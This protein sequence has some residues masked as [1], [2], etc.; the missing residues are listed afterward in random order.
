MLGQ[1]CFAARWQGHA[2]AA[3]LVLAAPLTPELGPPTELEPTPC[4]RV[5]V[6][7]RDRASLLSSYVVS[8]P[9]FVARLRLQIDQHG[10]NGSWTVAAG[11]LGPLGYTVTYVCLA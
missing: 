8:D 1:R 7:S 3:L 4:E 11:E 6:E 2:L 5:R 10:E 9:D